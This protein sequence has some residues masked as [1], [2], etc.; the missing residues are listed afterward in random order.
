MQNT[1][2]KKRQLSED[3]ITPSKEIDPDDTYDEILDVSKDK[4]RLDRKVVQYR[5]RNMMLKHLPNHLSPLPELRSVLLALF[6]S[7]PLYVLEF[8]AVGHESI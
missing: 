2:D 8:V 3:I 1:E 5:F 6:S 4:D 7:N